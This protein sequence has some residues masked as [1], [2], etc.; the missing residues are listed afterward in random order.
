[1]TLDRET[2]VVLGAGTQ[3]LRELA[4]D[5]PAAA[6]HHVRALGRWPV[7]GMRCHRR[8]AIPAEHVMK[9]SVEGGRKIG[10]QRPLSH[11]HL[12][13]L[14]PHL[15]LTYEPQVTTSWMKLTSAH[16]PLDA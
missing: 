6:G 5:E 13:V 12:D 4:Q 9:K 11:T 8:R 10:R 15:V 14:Q 1:M 7:A 16:A 2:E 3:F